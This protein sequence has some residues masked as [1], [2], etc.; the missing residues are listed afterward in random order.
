MFARIVTVADAKNA[1]AGVQFVTDKVMGM[2][3]QQ[4]GYRGMTLSRDDPREN[5]YVLSTWDSREEAEASDA[6]L[7]GLRAE[8]VGVTGASS[9]SSRIYEV[10]ISEVMRAP[11]PGCRLRVRSIASD[12]AT[13]EARLDA[14]RAEVLPLLKAAPGFC[15]MR[16]FG[17]PTTG[18]GLSGSV[19]VDQQSLEVYEAASAGQPVP[20]DVKFGE[21]EHRDIVLVDMPG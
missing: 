5:L 21:P 17:D 19:W 4:K 20:E 3:R 8:A 10:Y 1:E 2:L 16:I 15:T 13:R 12:P 18:E 9:V 6:A 11:Q 14:F 7:A